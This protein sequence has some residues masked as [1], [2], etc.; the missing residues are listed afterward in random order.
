[1]E[2]Q[3]HDRGGSPSDVPIDRSER[4]LADW[5]LTMDAIV[6]AL[7]GRGAMN[8]DEFRRGIEGMPREEYETATYYGRWLFATETILREKGLLAE[9]ELDAWVTG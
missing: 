4:Q 7:D 3:A 8:V 9:G 1:V 5:E 6:G 2:R